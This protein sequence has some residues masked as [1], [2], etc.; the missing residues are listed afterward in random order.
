MDTR[1]ASFDNQGEERFGRCLAWGRDLLETYNHMA[2]GEAPDDTARRTA[3]L[4]R[5]EDQCNYRQHKSLT[6]K[7]CKTVCD[8]V[9]DWRDAGGLSHHIQ[10]PP[11]FSWI[12]HGSCSH[13]IKKILEHM[14]RVSSAY[15]IQCGD[16][17]KIFA[18][19]FVLAYAGR[20]KM[21][22]RQILG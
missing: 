9:G 18:Y 6:A 14:K 2:E 17:G 16:L 22:Y 13:K 4:N 10:K 21:K 1:R 8:Q 7:A 19:V 11:N 5:A 15:E 12:F 3:F 20:L